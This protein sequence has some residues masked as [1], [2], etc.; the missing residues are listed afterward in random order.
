MSKDSIKCPKTF[1]LKEEIGVYSCLFY[2]IIKTLVDKNFFSRNGA[3]SKKEFIRMIE[4]LLKNLYNIPKL[5]K[6]QKE[7]IK[8]DR[9][10]KYMIY[11][12]LETLKIIQDSKLKELEFNF[13]QIE[14]LKK[15]LHEQKAIKVVKVIEN[16]INCA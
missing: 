12:I 6:N 10:I 7:L 9:K 13:A 3:L 15:I 5:P 4:N 16:V 8:K 2:T 14:E 11:Q 1:K